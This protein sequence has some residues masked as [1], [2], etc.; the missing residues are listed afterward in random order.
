MEKVFKRIV[1]YT[2]SPM[3]MFQIVKQYLL[4]QVN[5]TVKCS[6][7][8][9]SDGVVDHDEKHLLKNT[10]LKCLELTDK[11]NCSSIA[12]ESYIHYLQ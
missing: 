11:Y 9:G 12:I 3:A 1:G 8:L 4:N 2:I 5:S 6:M 7:P 10:T